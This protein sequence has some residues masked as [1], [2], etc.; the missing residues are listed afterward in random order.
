MD[1]RTNY[2]LNEEKSQARLAQWNDGTNVSDLSREL[3]LARTLLETAIE[4]AQPV[5][6]RD[7]L[8]TIAAL[9]KAE[10]Q[11]KTREGETW[12]LERVKSFMLRVGGI[13]NEVLQQMCPSNW[14]AISDAISE[15]FQEACRCEVER[16]KQNKLGAELRGAPESTGS[17]TRRLTD[18]TPEPAP[19]LP[20]EE[21]EDDD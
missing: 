17:E 13:Q 5:L 10:G 4:N 16:A 12:E 2:I 3:A 8:A 19:Q 9:S 15:R 18:L 11:R 20:S 7:L 14:S 6:A 21:S 1:Q